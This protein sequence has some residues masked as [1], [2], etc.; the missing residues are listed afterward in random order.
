MVLTTSKNTR[1]SVGGRHPFCFW[2]RRPCDSTDEACYLINDQ[3][4][5]F[6][7][8]AC[9]ELC[10]IDWV[11]EGM[12]FISGH[13]VYQ[14]SLGSKQLPSWAAVAI[15]AHACLWLV[16]RMRHSLFFVL[17][18]YFICLPSPGLLG[19]RHVV[20]EMVATTNL[21]SPNSRCPWVTSSYLWTKQQLIK[22]MI[23]KI[24][25]YPQLT[26]D[27]PSEKILESLRGTCALI[28]R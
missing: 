10:V 8:C 28:W 11:R 18:P 3:N 22:V 1:T 20:M 5:V 17:S 27:V 25:V 16:I 4:S 21:S 14:A 7:L 24:N 26:L 2:L 15:S 6:L 19:K 12:V 9:R 23:I 13:L